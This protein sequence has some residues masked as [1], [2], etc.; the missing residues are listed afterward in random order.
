M[1]NLETGGHVIA[2]GGGREIESLC[3]GLNLQSMFV[4]PSEEDRT[5]LSW[6]PEFV[7]ASKSIGE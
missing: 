4:G 7:I 3:G 5:R 1:T 6:F 2:E